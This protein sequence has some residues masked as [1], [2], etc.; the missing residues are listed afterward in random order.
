MQRGIKISALPPP[1]EEHREEINNL[2]TIIQVMRTQSYKPEGLTQANAVLTSS[3]PAVMAQLEQM[4]LTMNA[5]QTQLKTL[6]SDPTNK[7]RTKRQ[8]YCW[9][10][11]SNYTHVSKT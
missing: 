6:S 3:N 11:G 4:N 1:P 10:C 9:I 7:T 5:M 2:N 8:Y